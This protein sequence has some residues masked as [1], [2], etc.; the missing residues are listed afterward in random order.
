MGRADITRRSGP[1]IVK[2]TAYHIHALKGWSHR[3]NDTRYHCAAIV[4]TIDPKK[5]IDAAWPK[6]RTQS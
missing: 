4:I 3:G 2:T 6:E 1:R 5:P